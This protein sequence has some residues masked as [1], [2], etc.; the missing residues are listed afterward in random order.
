LATIGINI[1]AVDVLDLTFDINIISPMISITIISNGN[2]FI[3]DNEF[4]IQLAS[5]D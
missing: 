5:P 2:I 1:A 3:K 4:A